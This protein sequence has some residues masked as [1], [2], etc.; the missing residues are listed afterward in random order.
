MPDTQGNKF[1][2]FAFMAV[3]AVVVSMLI[4]YDEAY[5]AF[6][7]VIGMMVFTLIMRSDHR[8]PV[9]LMY[10]SLLAA[11]SNSHI[12]GAYGLKLRWAIMG[13]LAFK[14]F[15]YWALRK[16]IRVRVTGAHLIFFLLLI[17]AIISSV[18]S[19][20]AKKSFSRSISVFLFFIVVFL[21]FWQQSNNSEA[22]IKLVNFMAFFSPLIYFVEIMY[23]LLFPG[24]AWS[25][26]RLRAMS[27]N[28]NGLGLII[29]IT[30]PFIYW[31]LLSDQKP[32]YKF[33]FYPA[34]LVAISLLI[35][36]ASRGSLIAL[37]I[38]MIIMT[39]K[40]VPKYVGYVILLFMAMIIVTTFYDINA[41]S[42]GFDS[43][44][45]S[46]RFQKGGLTGRQ[47][48]WQKALEVGIEKPVFGHGF[49]TAADTFGS[50]EF[51]EH[52]G[53]YPHN[54]IL[55]I[56]VDLGFI[57]VLLVAM[58]HL[59][60]LRYFYTVFSKQYTVV[61]KGLPYLVAGIYLAG[62]FNAF[63]ESWMFSAGSPSAFPFWLMAML[64]VRYAK[65]PRIIE[66][67]KNVKKKPIPH[68]NYLAGWN[69]DLY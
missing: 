9:I 23:C 50:L 63:F 46:Q 68:V 30:L 33:Y 65:D 37:S 48:A 67:V 29:M 41:P 1:L 6:L 22:R 21:Y 56:F 28:P 19:V 66:E 34:I 39:V 44:V 16:H 53:A 42:K 27:G 47:E 51:K 8:L 10:V 38:C 59:V 69:K 61:D 52:Y 4:I 11:D 12:L 18:Y 20:D 60:L 35:L 7:T 24:A 57:G 49:G 58:L 40:L 25:D 31:Y 55:H 62:F 64:M 5:F 15:D 13:L 43:T 17:C 54:F 2:F 14:E 3:V 32:K 36:S 26:G 45:V